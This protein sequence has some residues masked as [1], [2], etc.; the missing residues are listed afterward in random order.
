[1][2]F[3]VFFGARLTCT[4]LARLND[5]VTDQI[6]FIIVLFVVAFFFVIVVVVLIVKGIRNVIFFLIVVVIVTACAC[7][8]R[9]WWGS[10]LWERSFRCGWLFDGITRCG[11]DNL[12]A[13]IV[14]WAT[15]LVIVNYRIS[16]TDWIIGSC[17][18]SCCSNSWRCRSWRLRWSWRRLND[19]GR[20][21]FIIIII[22]IYGRQRE[23]ESWWSFYYTSQILY[24]PP[25][26]SSKKRSI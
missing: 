13:T 16:I 25:R 19:T 18:I 4:T 7:R 21:T 17:I 1:M 5:I 9:Q 8:C 22:V 6:V 20:W 26:I 14:N 15:L 24:L 11:I 3:V 23:R 12:Y 2:R 10:D